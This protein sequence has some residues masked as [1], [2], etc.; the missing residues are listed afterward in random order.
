MAE[1]KL[2]NLTSE[3]LTCTICWNIYKDPKILECGHSYCAKCLQG[4]V[5]VVQKQRDYFECPICRYTYDINSDTNPSELVQ[6]LASDT[7]SLSLLKAVGIQ[8]DDSNKPDTTDVPDSP[9]LIPTEDKHGDEETSCACARH[10]DKHLDTYCSTHDIVV[11]AEC[12]K[13]NHSSHGCECTPA[14]R[15]I[16]KRLNALKCLVAQQVSD[17][18]SLFDCENKEVKT[19]RSMHEEIQ[20]SITDVEESFDEIFRCFK[21]RVESV[22]QKAKESVERDLSSSEVQRLQD[23]LITNIKSFAGDIADANPNDVLKMI[24][25]FCLASSDLQKNIHELSQKIK[26]GSLLK[27]AESD[28]NILDAFVSGVKGSFPGEFLTLQDIY[29]DDTSE[30]DFVIVTESGAFEDFGDLDHDSTDIMQQV[31]FSAKLTNEEKCMLSGVAL[32]GTTAVVIVDQRN[33]NVKKFKIP[34]GRFLNSLPI[35][36]EPHQAAT[37]RGSSDI[38]VSLWDIPKILIISTDPVLNIVKTIDTNTEY[39]GLASHVNDCLAASSIVSRRVDVLVTNATEDTGIGKQHTI[40]QSSRRRSFPDR[41]TATK[42][43]KVVV[44]NRRRN[45]V[46]CFGRNRMLLWSRRLKQSVADVACFRGRVFATIRDKNELVSFREDGQG[47]L[48]HLPTCNIRHPWA[49][50][51]FKDCLVITEDSPSDRVHI[52][53]FK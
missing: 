51:G 28:L 36:H 12:A 4:Y 47:R 7:L 45:E 8:D 48:E 25:D 27:Y 50:D 17:A 2:R 42:D 33:K 3:Y 39:I 31:T 37:L 5:S 24:S 40:Y 26:T 6:C 38:A 13:E 46:C 23:Y 15:V 49:L 52:I 34:E 21:R 35:E 18:S 53:V 22:R 32:I 43:G 29:E 30:K 16:N 44:R 14:K 9:K 11:C 1:R 10:R 41:L 20:K 19:I